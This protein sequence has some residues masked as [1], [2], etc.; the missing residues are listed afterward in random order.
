MLLIAGLMWLFN[1]YAPIVTINTS[2]WHQFGYVFIATAVLIDLS[3]VVQFFRQR[4]TINPLRPE[5]AEQLVISGLYRYSRNPMYVGLLLLLIG[6]L[7]L[8][9]SLS[10]M[11]ML[12]AF[13]LILNSQQII[14]EEKV[15]EQKFGQQYKDY[16]HVVRR[17]L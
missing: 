1:K 12:P 10:P 3:A 2:L 16:K 8:L 4:T 17:W 13:I 5:K 7:F 15:L 9:G 14:P 6:W 11:I